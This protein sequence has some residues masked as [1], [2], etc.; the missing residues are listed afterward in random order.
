MP[1]PGCTWR[2]AIAPGGKSTRSQRMTHCLPRSTVT[3]AASFAPAP[4]YSD[5]SQTSACPR[6]RA[7]KRASPEARS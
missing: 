7:P 3:S 4:P 1:G 6:R 2:Y 5:S